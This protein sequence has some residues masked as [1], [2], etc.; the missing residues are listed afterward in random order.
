[1]KK[2]T[3]G[4]EN[5]NTRQRVPVLNNAVGEGSPTGTRVLEG[6]PV[7]HVVS[8]RTNTSGRWDRFL[9]AQIHL[10]YVDDIQSKQKAA[11]RWF[12]KSSMNR[13]GAGGQ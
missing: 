5:G 10:L 3:Q 7:N 9:E 4:G 13:S 1:M 2:I 12:K 11:Q 8:Q 6:K